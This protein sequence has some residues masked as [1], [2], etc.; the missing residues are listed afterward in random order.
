MLKNEAGQPLFEANLVKFRL[1]GACDYEFV[2]HETTSTVPHK[3]GKTLTTEAGAFGIDFAVASYFKIDGVV[4]FEVLENMGYRL[5]LTSIR[6]ILHPEFTMTDRDGNAVAT[7]RMNVVGPRE[8]GVRGIGNK[9]NNT[10]IVTESA[11]TEAIFFAAFLL[12]RVDFSQSL[13]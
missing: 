11:D 2:N 9:Q 3:V 8:E 5:H 7:F 1:F 12:G 6:P 13:M 10:E 4:C